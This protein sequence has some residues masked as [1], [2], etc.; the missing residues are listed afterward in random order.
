[1]HGLLI[2]RIHGRTHGK[3]A[4][5][6]PDQLGNLPVF[7]T[8]RKTQHQHKHDSRPNPMVHMKLLRGPVRANPTQPNC[9]SKQSHGALFPASLVFREACCPHQGAKSSGQR[10]SRHRHAAPYSSNTQASRTIA[11]PSLPNGHRPRS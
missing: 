7:P 4:W 1:M 10:T 9:S 3:G 5:L 8:P 6:D 11:N 2:L